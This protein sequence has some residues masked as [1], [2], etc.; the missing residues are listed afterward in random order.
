MKVWIEVTNIFGMVPDPWGTVAVGTAVSAPASR[1]APQQATTT[2]E[3][4]RFGGTGSDELDSAAVLH[5]CDRSVAQHLQVHK[6]FR[7]DCRSGHH[8]RHASVPMPQRLI[9]FLYDMLLRMPCP[10]VSVTDAP[11]IPM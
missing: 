2:F 11:L 9:A 3:G 7:E 6:S 4:T 8:P 5:V 1:N 10:R